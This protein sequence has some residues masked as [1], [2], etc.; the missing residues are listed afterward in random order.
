MI[1]LAEAEHI[2][3]GWANR[4]SMSRGYTCTPHVDE[5]TLGYAVWMQLAPEARPE[6]GADVITIIDRETGRLS[7]W[8]PAPNDELDQHYNERRQV[9]IG[10]HQTSDPVAELR[11]EA[12]RRVSP[13]VAAHITLGGRLFRARGAKGDQEL[14]HHPIVEQLL[15]L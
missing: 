15:A 6:P 1:T 13:S 14:R 8:P 2:A 12:H 5:L 10:S 7:H 9:A 4:Q 3:T 11:R